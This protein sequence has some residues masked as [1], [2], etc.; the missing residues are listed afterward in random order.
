MSED[1][2]LSPRKTVD[3][4]VDWLIPK[5]EDSEYHL[6][7]L[8]TNGTVRVKCDGR[9]LTKSQ[10]ADLAG[11]KWS[12]SE[13]DFWAL[14]PDISISIDDVKKALGDWQPNDPRAT[15]PRHDPIG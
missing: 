3:Y 8:V 5:S 14:P 10:A 7:K 6:Y 12:P 1:K 2:W 13:G 11:K 9:L 4:F 15:R